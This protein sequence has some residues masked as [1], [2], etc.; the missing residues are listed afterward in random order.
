V[1]EQLLIS[2]EGLFSMGLVLSID[3]DSYNKNLYETAIISLMQQQG[4]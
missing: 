3:F 2:Q 4:V 1:T